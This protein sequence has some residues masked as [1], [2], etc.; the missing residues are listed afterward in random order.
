MTYIISKII[1]YFLI[2][3][4]D[5]TVTLP[6]FNTPFQLHLDSSQAINMNLIDMLLKTGN[7]KEKWNYLIQELK[8]LTVNFLI[9]LI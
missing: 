3:Q 4:L 6:H 8:L 5:S 1:F 7:E 2:S 9:C